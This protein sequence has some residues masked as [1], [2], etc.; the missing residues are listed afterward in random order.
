MGPDRLYWSAIMSLP[1]AER[2]HQLDAGLGGPTVQAAG[3][4]SWTASRA[5]SRSVIALITDEEKSLFVRLATRLVGAVET[6]RKETG[7]A[8]S[9]D[10]QRLSEQTRYALASE[11]DEEHITAA[12]AVG[13]EMTFGQAMAYALQK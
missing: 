6:L 10:Q 1:Q 9:P 3:S 4:A 5:S 12:L 13:R 2:P 7:Y 11:L 8:S